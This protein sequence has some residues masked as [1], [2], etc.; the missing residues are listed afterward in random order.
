MDAAGVHSERAEPQA[1]AIASAWFGAYRGA[2]EARARVEPLLQACDARG[3]GRWRDLSLGFEALLLAWNADAGADGYPPDVAG[4][5]ARIEQQLRAGWWRGHRLAQAALCTTRLSRSA[6]ATAPYV[7]LLRTHGP[8][9]DDPRPPAERACTDVVLARLLAWS[10]QFD[11]ALAAGVQADELARA[12]GLR[13]LRRHSTQQL[14]FTFLSVGDIEGALGVLE[15]FLAQET[16]RQPL[17]E[18]VRYNQ[19]LAY[20]IGNRFDAA[21]AVL[22]ANPWLLEPEPLRRSFTLATLC[23]C[24]LARVG[25]TERARELLAVDL[26]RPLSELPGGRRSPIGANQAWLHAATRLA[27]GEPARARAELEDYLAALDDDLPT[28]MNGTQLYRVLA[29]ACE[30]LDD[31]RGALEAL[32]RSQQFCFAWITASMASRLRALD[33]G[34]HGTGAAPDPRRLAERVH[35]VDVA[36]H[37]AGRQRRFLAQVTHE[38]RN[39]L[40]GVLGMTS[41]LMLSELD[42]RQRKYVSVAQS[43]AQ[44]LLALCNDILDLAKIEAGRFELDPRP[45]AVAGLLAEAVDVFSPQVEARGVAL[46][47]DADPRLP[48]MLVADRLR[49]KQIV[50]NLLSNASKFT[51]V[52]AILVQSSWRDGPQA[53]GGTLRVSVRD[54]GPGLSAEQRAHLFQEFRQADAAVAQSHGGTGLGLAL[55]RGLVELMGG[56]IGA[57]SE[58][59]RGSTFWFELPLSAAVREP[60]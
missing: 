41:L 16:E 1:Q 33:L 21:C 6:S 45:V 30:A 20:A 2:D 40:N 26:A 14:A 48:P 49:L 53:D 59:G 54:S 17:L 7:S 44:M 25:R 42:E 15:P 4:E 9:A 23:A 58:P 57:D 28:P 50:M 12:S 39:P 32:K 60:A 35:A 34:R 47:L 22:D 27:F 38:M 43:S 51:Q 52:G 3:D 55:C 10:A 24:I 8:A 19:L 5:V 36:A 31:P 46:V 13:P 18:R 56:T 11:E 37:D 29:E